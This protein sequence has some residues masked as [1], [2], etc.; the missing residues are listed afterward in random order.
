MESCENL[1]PQFNN[2]TNTISSHQKIKQVIGVLSSKGGVGKSFIAGVLATELTRAGFQVGILDADLTG[3]SISMFFGVHGP[4]ERGNYSF[5]P[6]QT[7]SGI[8]IISPNLL[9]ENGTQPFIWKNALAGKVIEELY[10]EVEWGLLDYLIIDLP[11]ATSEVTV[12][13]LQSIPFA[14][15][16]IV[17]QP[18]ELSTRIAEKTIL[19]AQKVNVDVIGIVENMSYYLNPNSG[20]EYYPF[21]QSHI[22][23][24]L[25][26]TQLPI[27]ARFPLSSEFCSLCDFGKIEEMIALESVELFDSF[28]TSL[29]RIQEK[30]TDREKDTSNPVEEETLMTQTTQKESAQPQQTTHTGHAFSDTVI[31][32][33]QNKDNMGT[34]EHPDAQ[35]YYLGSCG[36]RMQIDLQLVNDR[37]LDARFLADGCGATIA[38]G[39]MITKMACSKTI[40]EAE[41]ITSDE[42]IGV[43]GG[44]PEDHLHCAELAVM[45]LREAVID[46]VEGHENR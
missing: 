23:S 37:I 5:L 17:T 3:P 33:I 34:F 28:S 26:T 36:D 45:T 12:E 27:L 13:V 29:T 32:L 35:G 16:M 8:K 46:A 14:G 18:Q 24:I 10:K 2:Q 38:C 31:R 25:A 41:K 44:L 1:Q 19:L 7:G 42:L 9:V 20:E 21:G 15:V 11:P 43:L 40:Q 39:S 22:D 30:R 6:L 4:V